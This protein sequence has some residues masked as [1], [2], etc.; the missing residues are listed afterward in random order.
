[1]T[2]AGCATS[3]KN[4]SELN[5]A[6][7]DLQATIENLSLADYMA[8]PK[9]EEAKPAAKPSAP[10]KDVKPVTLKT[11]PKKK[12]KKG[13]V[14]AAG[15]AIAPTS[16]AAPA[17]PKEDAGV[18]AAAWPYGVGEKVTWVLRYGPIEGG[19]ATI[20]VEPPKVLE[21]EPVIHYRATV[22]SS[23][24]LEFFYKVD[25]EINSYVSLKNHIPVRQDIRQLESGR[26]GRRVV[27]FDQQ[28]HKAKFF[29][30]ITKKEGGKDD[31]LREDDVTPYAQDIFGAIFFFRFL[32]LT[33]HI[34]FP[35]HDRWKNWNNELT[36]LGDE[37]IHIFA[38][39]FDARHFKMMPRVSG[40]LTPK[41]DVEVWTWKHP[42]N[43]LL[44]FK[45]KIKLG[46]LTGEVKDI[47]EGAKLELPPPRLLTPT[48][49]E[50]T[51][52]E[53][54]PAQ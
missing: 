15:A 51:G 50:V 40:V 28:K 31:V 30:D 47:S 34:N 1:M 2:L 21:G 5:Q 38:G 44:Q 54:P 16:A 6:P 12:G 22:K 36:Y 18:Q 52:K 20:M 42:S 11:P 27:V 17:A 13:E 3:L 26:W 7:A 25:N 4:E 32:D 49:V 29:Q 10:P 19:V 48:N 37:K 14:V 33:K 43:L 39:D 53:E 41:G 46:A 35:V 23:K 24:L 45:A 9:P 8:S